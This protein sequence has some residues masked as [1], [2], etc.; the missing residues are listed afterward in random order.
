[1]RS[2]YSGHVGMFMTTEK[3][4]VAANARSAYYVALDGLR[5]LA[6][7]MVF[8]QHYGAGR[9]FVFGWGWTGVDIFFV[10]SGFLITGILYDSQ[11]RPHRYRDFYIRR[12]LR[13]FPL[14]YAVWIAILLLT[15]VA[16]W[17]WSWRWA[18]WPMYVGNYA[19]FLFLH[20]PGNPYRFDWITFG[21]V[22]NAWFGGPMHLY[23]GHFWSLCVEEQFYLIWPFVVYQVRRR[24]TLMKICIGVIFV[25]PLVRWLLSV[26]LPAPL[27]HMELFYR[28]LPTRIDALL[29]GGLIALC[30]RGPEQVLVRRIRRPLLAVSAALFVGLYLVSIKLLRLPLEGSASNWIGILG[31]TLID[32]FAAALILECIHPGSLLGRIMSFKPLRALGIVSYGFYVYHDLLHDFYSYFANR[33]FPK[34][35]YPVTLFVAF[36]C[37]VILSTISY[38]VL[39]R[40]MLRLKDRFTGQVHTAPRV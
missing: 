5:A 19:R 30:L 12:T 39:E 23:I 34:H 29:I 33:Y 20:I 38:R 32:A 3:P 21:P 24:E 16:Q 11:H 35:A 7:I 27:L 37:T 1:M 6:V 4:P 2:K 15:P 40:P 25:L 9:A 36:S 31:F 26:V 13:I 28:S 17:Q 10:L 22:V 18:L 14:Y 8:F